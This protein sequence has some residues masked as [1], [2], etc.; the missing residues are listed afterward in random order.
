MLEAAVALASV[1]VLLALWGTL[2][3]RGRERTERRFEAV[4]EEHLPVLVRKRRQL[5]RI[6]D[7]GVVDR[8]RWER[9]IGYFFD[10]VVL[11]TL[12]PADVARIDERLA[13]YRERLE[14]IVEARQA[15]AV[16]QAKFERVRNGVEFEQFCAEELRRG[17]AWPPPGPRATRGPT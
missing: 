17:G 2:R 13:D 15:D 9:E 11:Q 5:V 16:L 6:D 8:S 12:T 1:F 14:A 4:V 10:K 3:H 7:Y